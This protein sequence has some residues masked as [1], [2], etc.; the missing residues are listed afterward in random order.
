[1]QRTENLDLPYILPSQAQKHVTHNEAI[2]ALDAVV[3]LSVRDRDRHA[4]PEDPAA[5]SR[6]IIADAA[7]GEWL[8]RPNQIAAW[9]DGS[10]LF[11]SP[12]PGWLAYVEAERAHR[13]WDGSAWVFAAGTEPEFL[14]LAIN[15]AVADEHNRLAVQGPAS[16]FNHEGGSHRLVVNKEITADTAS[17]VLQT[18]FEG[19]A[20]IGLAG[21]DR[22]HVKLSADGSAWRHALIAGP[23]GDLACGGL[24]SL[25]SFSTA[26]LP[27]S[28][29]AGALAFLSGPAV[30][31]FSD[32][33]H[34]RR[35]DTGAKIHP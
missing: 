30:V 4:P 26:S 12:C 15:G 29:P 34:W 17:L 3:Q 11:Y 28:A 14:R 2:R 32:G 10:W 23:E 21:D 13:V 1:M 7:S 20:E 8:G 33:A 5:G 9:Q 25:A 19:R 35:I 16:L 18:G 24:L 31:V 22:L 27:P 6:H